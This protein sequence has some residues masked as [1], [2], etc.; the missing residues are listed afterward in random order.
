MIN[1]FDKNHDKLDLRDLLVGEHKGSGDYGNLDNYLHFSQKDGDT[2]I[3]ISST[4]AFKDG[5]Y[6]AAKVDQ[7]ITLSDVNLMDGHS[8]H[9]VI[10]DLVQEGKLI[11]D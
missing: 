3:E 6:N 1:D 5:N 8:S 11:T 7:V 10:Q 2:V 4:G 9:E